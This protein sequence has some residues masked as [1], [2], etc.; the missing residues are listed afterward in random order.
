MSGTLKHTVSKKEHTFLF[1]KHSFD[2]N[3]FQDLLLQPHF[4]TKSVIIFS[5][6][7]FQ[8]LRWTN[9]FPCMCLRT[10][11][12]PWRDARVLRQSAS[13]KNV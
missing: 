10:Y 12:L 13:G 7:A 5:K 1:Y 4:V 11:N 3:I 9:G 8:F 6:S 2:Q